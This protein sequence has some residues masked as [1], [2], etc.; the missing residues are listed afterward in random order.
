MTGHWY[1]EHD[2]DVQAALPSWVQTSAEVVRV[3]DEILQGQIPG[4]PSIVDAFIQTLVQQ[5]IPSWVTTLVYLMDNM[6]TIFSDLRAKGEMDLT[7]VGGPTVLY[8]TETWDSFIFYLLSRCGPNIGA[9]S[10][11][12]PPLCAEVDV[13]TSDLAQANFNTTVNPFN[14]V[15]SG[16]QLLV[17]QPRTVDLELAGIISYVVNQAIST[18]T[19]YSSLTGP[20][21]DP[22]NGALYNLIDCVDLAQP[23]SRP[24]F[25]STS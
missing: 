11:G 20:P 2:F 23:W 14:A 6:V 1:T 9:T 8:G 24:A 4:L 3:L 22:Q 7:A 16:N 15:V 19:G 21:G 18:T 12:N 17:T 10:P 5:Y 13:S 25:R